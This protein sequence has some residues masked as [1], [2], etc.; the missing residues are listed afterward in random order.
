M[1]K[2]SSIKIKC[3]EF[4]CKF[5]TFTDDGR[6]RCLQEIEQAAFN[7]VFEDSYL[8]EGLKNKWDETSWF[9]IATVTILEIF[10]TLNNLLQSCRVGNLFAHAIAF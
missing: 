1:P 3:L 7:S 8:F 10:F 5:L 4:Q 9:F 6:L 2:I